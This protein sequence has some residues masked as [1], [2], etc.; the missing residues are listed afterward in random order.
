MLRK[1]PSWSRWTT[2]ARRSLS[3]RSSSR[4]VKVVPVLAQATQLGH[5]IAAYHRPGA[6][7]WDLR[8][9]VTASGPM[10]PLEF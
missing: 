9:P 7:V 1:G 5:A 2:R 8:T 6:D 4:P 3:T 10:D